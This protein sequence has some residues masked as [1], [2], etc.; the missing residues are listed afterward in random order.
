M[1]EIKRNLFE[2]LKRSKKE[3]RYILLG[4]KQIIGLSSQV[5]TKLSNFKQ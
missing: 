5:L 1:R 3:E 4:Y 2:I